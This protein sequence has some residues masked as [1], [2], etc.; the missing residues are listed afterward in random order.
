LP[1]AL[2]ILSFKG[3]ET[4]Y[5]GLWI[6]LKTSLKTCSSC[7]QHSTR[8]LFVARAICHSQMT[9]GRQLP[10]PE[11]IDFIP[12]LS[13][14][15]HQIKD[16]FILGIFQ[17]Q[18]GSS[19]M[20]RLPWLLTFCVLNNPKSLTYDV[21]YQ[22]LLYQAQVLGIFSLASLARRCPVTWLLSS[23]MSTWGQSNPRGFP[24]LKPY[25]FSREPWI[26]MGEAG[27][28]ASTGKLGPRQLNIRK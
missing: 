21:I 1:W 20:F 3:L 27:G 11:P 5:R 24:K 13:P 28:E 12:L 25:Q 9:W 17:F 10:G 18:W 4:W 6:M 22:W 16:S 15:V 26:P 2:L 23:V 19:S 14:Y 7:T 8:N